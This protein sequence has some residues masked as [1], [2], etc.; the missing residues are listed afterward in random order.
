[1]ASR[2]HTTYKKRQ[3]E[4]QRLEKQRDKVVRR[5]QRKAGLL[6]ADTDE[7]SSTAELLASEET[8]L[9][10]TPSEPEAA[11]HDLSQ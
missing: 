9:P 4:L 7:P 3:K 5:Q 8:N 6:P 10:E 11:S 1:M 2:P